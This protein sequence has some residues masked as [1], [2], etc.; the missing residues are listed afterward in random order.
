[1]SF[2][3]NILLS[4]SPFAGE[5]IEERLLK[6]YHLAKNDKGKMR[7]KM[8][9]H[10]L[11]IERSLDL[12]KPGGRLAIVLPQGVLNNTNMEYVRDY[13]LDQARILAVVGLE[14][15]TFKP[16]AGVKT[17]LVFLQKWQAKD[18][19]AEAQAKADYP[20]FMA[21]SKKSGKNN[22]HRA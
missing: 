22:F 18:L 9:R 2:W 21:T 12:I 4:N 8:E 10:I 16:H 17:S 20:I 19:A 1:M 6:N 11:F 3:F 15:N 7:H 13:L 5:I 14:S